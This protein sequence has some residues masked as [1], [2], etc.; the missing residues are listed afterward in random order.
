MMKT[1]MVIA[2][3]ALALAGCAEKPKIEECWSQ[4]AKASVQTMIEDW[5]VEKVRDDDK[6]GKFDEAGFRKALK[7]ELGTFMAMDVNGIGVLQ[8]GANAKAT[9]TRNDGTVLRGG[10]APVTFGIYPGENKGSVYQI[11]N[12]FA[13]TKL[14]Q[15]LEQSYN[16]GGEASGAQ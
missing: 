1:A 4:G 6:S 8:C 9:I 7:V 13:A 5:I 11:P 12:G 16:R 3:A 15:D 2:V 14:M 10:P